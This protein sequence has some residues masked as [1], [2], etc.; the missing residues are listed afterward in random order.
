MT[1][2]VWQQMLNYLTLIV[3]IKAC[4]LIVERSENETVTFSLLTKHRSI[5]DYTTHTCTHAHAHTHTV[6]NALIAQN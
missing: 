6:T 1:N 5:L 4:C 3:Y 2:A